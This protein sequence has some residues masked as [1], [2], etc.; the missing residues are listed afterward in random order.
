MTTIKA[1]FQP[2]MRSL[3]GQTSPLLAASESRLER[4]RGDQRHPRKN[5]LQ[6]TSAEVKHGAGVG[7]GDSHLEH[8]LP[9]GSSEPPGTKFVREGKGIKL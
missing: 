5:I 1:S 6:K 3:P 9:A 8:L 7:V 2:Y 4:R